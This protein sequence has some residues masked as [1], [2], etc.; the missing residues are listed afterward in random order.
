MLSPLCFFIGLFSILLFVFFTCWQIGKKSA[1]LKCEQK[2]GCFLAATKR[3]TFIGFF[4]F[5]FYQLS[6]LTNFFREFL[7]MFR[8]VSLLIFL[9]FQAVNLS[10]KL[11]IIM[12]IMYVMLLLIIKC[13]PFVLNDYNNLEY[14]SS[15]SSFFLI[16]VAFLYTVEIS[17][18]IKAICFIFINISNIIFCVPWF[19]G[20]IRIILFKY[21]ALLLKYAPKPFIFIVVFN[22]V[23][24]FILNENCFN[25]KKIDRKFR[26]VYRKMMNLEKNSV[27]KNKSFKSIMANMINSNSQFKTKHMEFCGNWFFLKKH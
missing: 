1:R 17:N 20:M 12:F 8:K 4:S 16:F 18:P 5:Y 6:N 24:Q 27:N 3:N 26:S 2:W 23:L 10:V 14:Y 21:S 11:T 22:Q 13:Q 15:L 7:I 9:N 19:F 25:P